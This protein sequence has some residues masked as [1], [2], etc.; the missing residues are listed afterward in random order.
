M[1]DKKLDRKRVIKIIEKVKHL[2]R[3]KFSNLHLNNDSKI[4]VQSIPFLTS[5][6]TRRL[7]IWQIVINVKAAQMPVY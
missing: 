3:Y 4:N 2:T 7:L 1:Q 6:N 5:Y